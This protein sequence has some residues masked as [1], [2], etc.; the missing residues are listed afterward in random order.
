MHTAFFN[1]YY[2]KTII[3]LITSCVKKSTDNYHQVIVSDTLKPL[4]Y[5]VLIIYKMFIVYKIEF[6][7]FFFF[8]QLSL[9]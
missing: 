9:G 5:Q 4:F 3:V 7:H 6:H 8:S 2:I 1:Q